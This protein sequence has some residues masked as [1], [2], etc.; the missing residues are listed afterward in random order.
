MT[1]ASG[2]HLTTALKRIRHAGAGI[3]LLGLAGF[4]TGHGAEAPVG[5]V[6]EPV[7]GTGIFPATAG[8]SFGDDELL[9]PEI[10]QSHLPTTLGKYAL[11][12]WL[13][14][15]LGDLRNRDHLRLT[16]GVPGPW[17][18]EPGEIHES[19]DEPESNQ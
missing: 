13:N 4:P 8:S 19:T 12:L 11:R 6:A 18:D 3:F 16:T 17:N 5:S 15:H 9:I 10:F 14:P 7:V 2:F 1:I